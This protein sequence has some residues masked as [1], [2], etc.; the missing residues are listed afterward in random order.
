MNSA[1]AFSYAISG[2]F[3]EDTINQYADYVNQTTSMFQ[4]M[5][6]WLGEQAKKTLNN[7]DNFLNSRAWEMSKRLLNTQDGEYVSRY[8]IGYLG[9]VTALQGAQGYMRDYIMA[10]PALQQA[11]LDEEIEGYNGEFSHFCNGVGEANLFYRRAM[12]GV[13]NLQ[14]VDGKQHLRHTHYN[15]SLSGRISFREREDIH[16]TWRAI[17][18]H[19]LSS[20]FDLTSEQGHKLKSFA[21]QETPVEPPADE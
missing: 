12:N 17:D 2:S 15:D 20:V 14:E 19:R 18:H 21:D 1:N 5:G 16:K 4:N 10:H 6:G 9:S 7:F 3:T 8:A 13:L 11:Y